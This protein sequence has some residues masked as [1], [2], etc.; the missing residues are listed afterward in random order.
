[1]I[2][3]LFFSLAFASLTAVAADEP[4][5]APTSGLRKAMSEAAKGD[6]QRPRT[7]PLPGKGLVR[8]PARRK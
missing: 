3:R 6:A 7:A 2:A 4:P 8:R 1:M 5:P